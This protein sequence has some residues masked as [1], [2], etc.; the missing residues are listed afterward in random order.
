MN[1]KLFNNIKIFGF[2]LCCLT[3]S[4]NFLDIVPVEQPDLDD[5]TQDF[6]STLGF[7]HS[8]YAGLQ[9]PVQFEATEASADE[10]AI[11]G[12]YSLQGYSSLKVAHDVFT[13]NNNEGRWDT[14]YK[15]IGQIH[16]FLQEL[17]DAPVSDLVKEEWTAEANFL[18]AYYHFEILRFY[19]PCPIVDKLL[20]QTATQAEYPGRMHYDYVTD[21]IVKLLDEKVIGIL[22]S[23]R[24]DTE[25][26]R[27]TTPI[28]KA[29]K[30]RVLLYAASPLWNGKFPYPDWKNVKN[31]K[32]IET[33]GYGTALVGTTYNPEKWTRAEAACQDALN[34]ARDA[35]YY[36]YG[37]KSGDEQLQVQNNIPMPYIPGLEGTADEKKAFQ[38]K[39]LTLRYMLTAKG[40]E[41]NMELLWE[42]HKSTNFVYGNIPNNLMKLNNGSEYSGWS[43]S[44]PY[45]Y[46]IEHFYTNNGTLPEIAASKGKYPKKSEWLAPA[47]ITGRSELFNIC[48]DREPRFYAWI[49]FHQG[50]YSSRIANGNPVTLDTRDPDKQG[51]N[52]QKYNRNHLVTGFAIQK[53]LSPNTQISS[54]GSGSVPVPAY[55]LIRMAELYLNL[56]ECQANLS[57]D[58]ITDEYATKAL[59]NLNAVHQRAGLKAITKE[60]L[61]DMPLIDWIKNERYVEFYA[62][63]QRYFDVRR[64]VEGGKYLVPGKREGLRAE[65]KGL[66]YDEFR[67][68]IPVAQPYSWSERRYLMPIYYTEVNSN[69]QLV[70]APG[71]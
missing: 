14:F 2:A 6:N 55:P 43:S 45:L 30:A 68:R 8:C 63:G 46:A 9:S 57:A 64:W 41:G 70:Q 44:S 65:E 37:T 71:Y 54:T 59:E 1:M 20:P 50:D 3:S 29:L 23:T 24:S 47:G 34:A 69:P 52:P 17:Q 38:N 66:S 31:G 49:G 42:V 11:P 15:S 16:L 62:E 28:A 56:A 5:A 13:A 60:D 58:G 36:L 12:E 19:G 51:Y 32:E 7:L 27:A 10:Y 33:P 22:P 25:I 67:Q 35:G 40:K 48:V 53:F 61:N 39:V 18:L 4:C 21:W 26:G